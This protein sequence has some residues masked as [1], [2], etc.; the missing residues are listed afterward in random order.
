MARSQSRAPSGF[1]EEAP[2]F[3]A[4]SANPR[5]PPYKAFKLSPRA[6]AKI[7][8]G[9]R[10]VIPAAFREAAGM[11]E[12]AEVTIALHGEEVRIITHR[13]ALR[14]IQQWARETIPRDVSLVDELI[15]DRI[16]EER[17]EN[18]DGR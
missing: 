14:R 2:S 7:G 12:G 16:V 4:A 18:E 1:A 8:P 13:A 17:V 5:L 10:L 6:R 3:D 9:G 15:K 11:E